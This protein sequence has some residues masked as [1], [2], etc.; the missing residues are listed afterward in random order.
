MTRYKLNKTQ[1]FLISL[2]IIGSLFYTCLLPQYLL[3]ELNG[4]N[5]FELIIMI[6]VAL[7]TLALGISI[8]LFLTLPLAKRFNEINKENEKNNKKN[9][10]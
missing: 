9:R 7:V 3:P 10:K 1:Y 6:I 8:G 2:S 4:D 5:F